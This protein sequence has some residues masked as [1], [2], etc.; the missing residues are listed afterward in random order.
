MQTY[1]LN[2]WKA[3]FWSSLINTSVQIFCTQNRFLP[4]VIETV[5]PFALPVFEL[6]HLKCNWHNVWKAHWGLSPARNGLLQSGVSVGW[7]SSLWSLIPSLLFDQPAERAEQGSEKEFVFG[8]KSFLNKFSFAEKALRWEDIITCWWVGKPIRR[9][10]AEIDNNIRVPNSS[11][12][13]IKSALNVLVKRRY[14]QAIL[15]ISGSGA[16]AQYFGETAS[17]SY[18]TNKILPSL[19]DANEQSE[20]L[21]WVRMFGGEQSPNKK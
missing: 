12:L 1:K 4:V 7:M 2:H 8:D 5:D 3:T 19:L 13:G 17:C 16:G 10:A 18:Q 11:K 20:L 21:S 14:G 6:S 9:V 15:P